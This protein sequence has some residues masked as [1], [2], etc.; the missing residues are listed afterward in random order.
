MSNT[1]SIKNL[2]PEVVKA[3]LTSF[4]DIETEVGEIKT[5]STISSDSLLPNE[6][7]NGIDL[8]KIDNSVLDKYAD[9]INRIKS[10]IDSVVQADGETI[11]TE[12]TEPITINGLGDSLMGI[13]LAA[14]L[15][16]AINGLSQGMDYLQQL[17]NKING[18]NE[19]Q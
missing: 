5:L 2:D 14:A 18:A 6:F 16:S 7:F 15:S 3:S 4:D 17:A 13:D 8:S 10:Y 1:T 12:T 19:F 11:T 9:T